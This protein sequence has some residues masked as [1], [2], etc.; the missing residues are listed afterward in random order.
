MLPSQGQNG[1]DCTGARNAATFMRAQR[2]RERLRLSKNWERRKPPAGLRP[3]NST[4]SG[5]AQSQ[6]QTAAGSDGTAM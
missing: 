5:V 1:T 2:N 3:R 6:S 4:G